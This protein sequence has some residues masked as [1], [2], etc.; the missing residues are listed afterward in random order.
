VGKGKITVIKNKTFS[1]SEI[2][3]AKVVL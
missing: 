1:Y 3:R 2:I